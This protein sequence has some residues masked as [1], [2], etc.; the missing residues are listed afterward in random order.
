MNKKNNYAMTYSAFIG[1]IFFLNVDFECSIK[2]KLEFLFIAH[3]SAVI[4]YQTRNKTKTF[5]S[6][7]SR[8]CLF[9]LIFV[10]FFSF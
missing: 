2:L 8:S 7:L 5:D 4:S 9:A 1:S 10:N 3:L 6:N